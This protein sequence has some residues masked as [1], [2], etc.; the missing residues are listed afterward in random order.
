M[1][2]RNPTLST[3]PIHTGFS[4]PTAQSNTWKEH[5]WQGCWFNTCCIT[6]KVRCRGGNTLKGT[7]KEQG[8]GEKSYKVFSLNPL[9]QIEKN[10]W[11][12]S[13]SKSWGMNNPAIFSP[14]SA[15]H[16]QERK[17]T[18]YYFAQSAYPQPIS[19]LRKTWTPSTYYVSLCLNPCE[20][21][22]V[23]QPLLSLLFIWRTFEITV[24]HHWRK[25]S[26]TNSNGACSPRESCCNCLTQVAVWL[27]LVVLEEE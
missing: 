2:E 22:K 5:I 17:M 26:W 16:Y 13:F 24:E 10:Y 21:Q 9:Y 19:W 7:A 18:R 20:Q 25:R 3:W 11:N 8:H 23:N 27:I 1:M 6:Q 12:I 15:E 4:T 14:N